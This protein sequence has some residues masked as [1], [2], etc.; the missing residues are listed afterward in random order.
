MCGVRKPVVRMQIPDLEHNGGNSSL[1]FP[2]SSSHPPPLSLFLFLSPPPTSLSLSFL[3]PPPL[4][5]PLPLS[6][7]FFEGGQGSFLFGY[8]TARF[9]QTAQICVNKS[10]TKDYPSFCPL[11]FYSVFVLC[12]AVRS[13]LRPSDLSC[14]LQ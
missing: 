14:T 8:V 11:W 4:L 3:I 7:S 13:F 12:K 1:L 10:L 2:P 9:S 6:L 5:P